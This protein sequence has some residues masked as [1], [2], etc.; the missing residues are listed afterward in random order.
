MIVADANKM[1]DAYLNF[2]NAQKTSA[3]SGK[4]LAQV[5]A[6]IGKKQAEIASGG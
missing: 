5:L 3:Q 2:T 1:S 6:E 4:T